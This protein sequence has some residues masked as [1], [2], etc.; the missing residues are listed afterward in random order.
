MI[1][2]IES[3]LLTCMRR[4]FWLLPLNG[5]FLGAGLLL[6]FI[7]PFDGAPDE[8]THYH[9]NVEFLIRNHRLPVSGQDDLSAYLTGRVNPCGRTASR[10]SY[11][12]YPAFHSVVQAGGAVMAHR[13]FG[14]EYYLGARL[15]SLCFGLL[16]LNLLYL[17][18]YAA[19]G[20]LLVAGL[21]AMAAFIPQVV[22]TASYIN[23]DIHSLAFS[24]LLVWSL[25]R[26]RAAASNLNIILLGFSVA[27]LLVCKYNYF[28]YFPFLIGAALFGARRL[29]RRLA[30]KTALAVTLLPLAISGGWYLRNGML[31][32]DPLGQM[33][34]L[35]TLQS[36]QALGAEQHM[37]IPVLAWMVN[38]GLAVSLFR[39]FFGVFGYMDVLLSPPTYEILAL[40]VVLLAGLFAAEL[41]RTGDRRLFRAFGLL[42]ALGVLCASLV[43]YNCLKWDYQPQGRYLFPLI[44]PTVLTAAIAIARHRH[45]FKYA[46][47]LAAFMLLLLF[48]AMMVLVATYRHGSLADVPTL[49]YVKPVPPP[50][51]GCGIELTVGPDVRVEQ[52][53]DSPSDGLRGLGLQT[54]T[55]RWNGTGLYRIEVFAKERNL[56]IRQAFITPRDVTPNSWMQFFFKPIPDS[57]NQRYRLVLTAEEGDLRSPARIVRTETTVQD[58]GRTAV[59]GVEQSGDFLIKL[60]Y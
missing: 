32:G 30:L 33:F 56:P 44:A 26:F 17:A 31:Y 43:L 42:A 27:M 54:G 47:I 41:L 13:A 34:F 37:R 40:V 51:P 25:V 3:R 16:F 8:W 53:F 52:A 36:M 49:R 39:S 29:P 59:N 21:G 28:S 11:T 18:V 2:L 19:T 35:K 6:V 38:Q 15:V 48:K 14:C 20:G 7:I 23:D 12:M 58:L 5:L 55:G 4:H 60:A 46:A 22:F 50:P 57:G 10:C 24:A 45:L 9:Y 1:N